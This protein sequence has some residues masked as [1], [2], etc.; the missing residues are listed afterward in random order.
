MNDDP[1]IQQIRTIRHHISER[2]HHNPEELIQH[3]IEREQ[4]HPERFLPITND[5]LTDDDTKDVYPTV[6]PSQSVRATS[7][8]S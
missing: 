7:V 1:I 6:R 3:Y 4:R 5:V 8:S 2:Y